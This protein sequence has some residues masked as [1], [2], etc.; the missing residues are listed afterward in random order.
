MYDY[1]IIGAGLTGITLCKKLREKGI[2]NV[3]VLEKEG[4]I[5]GLCRTR[6][7]NG[8]TLDIG[9]GHFFNTKYPAIFDYVFSYLPKEEF[10]YYKRVSKIKLGDYTIDYPLESNI[11]Q[12]TLPKQV[13]F[14]MS[15]IR[16]GESMGLKEPHNYEEWIRWKLGDMVCDEYMLPYNQKLWGVAP[17][18]MDIDWLH[19]IPRVNVEEVLQYSLQRQQDTSKFPAHVNFYYPKRGGFQRIVDAL[20]KDERDYICCSEKV[21]QLDYNGQYWKVNGT[22][23]AKAVINTAPWP[24]LQRALD[25]PPELLADFARLRYNRIVVSLYESD[26]EVNWH[27][28]YVPDINTPYHREFFISNFAPDSKPGGIYRETNLLRHQA[29]RK[30][31]AEVTT[32]AAYP[33]PVLGHKKAM[34]NI[35]NFLAERKLYGVGRWGRHAYQN[36]DVAM[37][38]AIT[39][40]EKITG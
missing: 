8:H 14:L 32:A 24:D 3:I 20:A 34:D 38:D 9:G 40:V 30:A 22:H 37:L 17:E 1:L 11:W 39:F 25:I 33:I 23:S 6:L 5:G 28:R 16:N 27:W 18:E 31:L 21:T 10:Q 13:S 19:K 26:Y 12:L 2:Q 29:D 4:E 15:I 35:L 7:I 36:A